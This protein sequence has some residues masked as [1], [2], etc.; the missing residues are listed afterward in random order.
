MGTQELQDAYC[1]PQEELTPIR[2]LAAAKLRSMMHAYL[3][4]TAAV[5]T[6][7]N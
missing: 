3:N 6:V 7:E 5:E 1:P 2:E 4:G